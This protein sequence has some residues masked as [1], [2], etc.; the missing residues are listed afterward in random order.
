MKNKK[1]IQKLKEIVDAPR[2]KKMI[3]H[4]FNCEWDEVI[5]L[6]EKYSL[7]INYQNPDK[8]TVLILAAQY[9]SVEMVAWLVERNVNEDLTCLLDMTAYDLA[10]YYKN[11]TSNDNDYNDFDTIMGILT[12]TI[13]PLDLS[14]SNSTLS[15]DNV[16]T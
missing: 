6:I 2:Y 11:K 1:P 14:S 12:P 16:F 13:S 3:K 9:N 8:W 10:K 4:A 15:F 7:D 5:T